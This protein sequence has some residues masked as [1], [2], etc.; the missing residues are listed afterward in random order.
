MMIPRENRGWD[1][2]QDLVGQKQLSQL[3]EIET[4]IKY[5]PI[6]TD[7]NMGCARKQWVEDQA[8]IW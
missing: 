7:I 1:I 4:P 2:G 5:E 6:P 8:M 3:S